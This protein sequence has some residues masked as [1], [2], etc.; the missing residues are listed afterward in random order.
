[1]ILLCRCSLFLVQGDGEQ[2]HLV[3]QLFDVHVH[4]T[5]DQC[6][7]SGSAQN[8]PVRVEW[9]EGLTGYVARTGTCLNIPDAYKVSLEK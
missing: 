3:S 5:K 4:S 2:R 6:L 9:G 8:P 7:D 1:M